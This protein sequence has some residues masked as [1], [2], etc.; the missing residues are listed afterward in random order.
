ME[1]G[2]RNQILVT[3][4][5]LGRVAG[6]FSSPV[7]LQMDHSRSQFA[8]VGTVRNVWNTS[9]AFWLRVEIPNTGS[10][11]RADVIA[12]FTH[13]PPAIT[14]GSVGFGRDYEI[15]FNEDADTYE[16]VNAT[17]EEFSL[18]PFPAGYDSGGLSPVFSAAFEAATSPTGTHADT[19]DDVAHDGSA[20]EIESDAP[21]RSRAR[22]FRNHARISEL[23]HEVY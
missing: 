13:E 18:T 11:V 8:N 16:L 21:T 19:L 6:N 12:D 1:P 9:D 23:N 22:V 14:D 3:E 2:V 5:F 17:L 10:T 7:P 15:Q 4:G 20:A